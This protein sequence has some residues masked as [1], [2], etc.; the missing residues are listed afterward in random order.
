MAAD[1]PFGK[2]DLAPLA[3]ITKDR[4]M[5]FN[6]WEGLEEYEML[7][8]EKITTMLRAAQPRMTPPTTK[9]GIFHS[10]L[11]SP[12]LVCLFDRLFAALPRSGVRS[13]HRRSVFLYTL[14]RPNDEGL[15]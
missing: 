12:S 11:A 2:H 6:S 7:M 10:R 9:A 1:G 8:R 13:V 5:E 15:A 14:T 4:V 3:Q